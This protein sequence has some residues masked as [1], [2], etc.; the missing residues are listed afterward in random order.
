[1]ATEGPICSLEIIVTDM[2]SPSA[3]TSAGKSLRANMEALRNLNCTCQE[4]QELPLQNVSAMDISDKLRNEGTVFLAGSPANHDPSGE[5]LPGQNGGN[6]S[7]KQDVFFSMCW[8]TPQ[9]TAVAM[10]F[11]QSACTFLHLSGVERSLEWWTVLQPYPPRTFMVALAWF[12]SYR[13][14]RGLAENNEGLAEDPENADTMVAIFAPAAFIQ[15]LHWR[16]LQLDMAATVLNWLSQSDQPGKLVT[17]CAFTA[18]L[19]LDIAQTAHGN[20]S[21]AE[22]SSARFSESPNSNQCVV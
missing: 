4:S 8:N 12:R 17:F 21:S 10:T 14:S 19:E 20:V 22:S 6:I 2:T 16:G 11:S 7:F 13:P 3:E 1:M 9:H 18:E 15:N 5:R